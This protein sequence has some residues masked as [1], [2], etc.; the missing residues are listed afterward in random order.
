M[1]P[2]TGRERSI[3][4]PGM[5]EQLLEAGHKQPRSRIALLLTTYAALSSR[6]QETN[7]EYEAQH[8]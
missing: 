3:G 2:S 1:A 8:P 4:Q 7:W 6:H 5:K